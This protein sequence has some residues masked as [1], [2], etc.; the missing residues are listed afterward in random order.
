MH[1]ALRVV[2]TPQKQTFASSRHELMLV[3]GQALRRLSTFPVGPAG[4]CGERR[5]VQSGFGR[6]EHIAGSED[7]A[8]TSA[9]LS[10]CRNALGVSTTIIAPAT[11]LESVM[12]PTRSRP[13][14]TL[15]V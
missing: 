3:L 10:A 11:R 9:A 12:K 8:A 6:K 13:N 14:R 15:A 1:N 4:L 5:I 2:N 7:E